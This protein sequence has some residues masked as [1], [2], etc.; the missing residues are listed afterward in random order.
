ME[1][2][3][4]GFIVAASLMLLVASTYIPAVLVDRLLAKNDELVL[5]M[6][7]IVNSFE[8]HRQKVEDSVFRER[9]L[10]QGAQP[11]F[12]P[13][14]IDRNELIT[15][16]ANQLD[17]AP[18]GPQ[19]ST[20]LY[21]CNEGY[22]MV[23]YISDRFGFRNSD[24]V[25][26][27]EDK[28]FVIGD[29]FVHG[30]CMP[31][32]SN[33]ITGQMHEVGNVI[34][35][36]SGSNAPIHYAAIAK[37]IVS[38]FEPKKVIM[39]FYPNDNISDQRYNEE[40]YFYKYYW[41]RRPSSYF[42]SEPPELTLNSNLKSFYESVGSVLYKSISGSYEISDD[43]LKEPSQYQ[44]SLQELFETIDSEW[45]F[46]SGI[47]SSN[48]RL[49]NIRTAI[50][51]LLQHRGADL[52]FAAQLAIDELARVCSGSCTP[53]V[54]YIPES[55]LRRPDA[56][57]DFF[58]EQL[59]TYSEARGIKFVNTA[60]N[61]RS[62]DESDIYALKGPHLSPLGNKLVADMISAELNN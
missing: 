33:T 60:P 49:N 14:L 40:S 41:N 53:A 45:Q 5:E 29:S 54:A 23:N 3:K 27:K 7:K 4:R 50:R 26:D 15:Q 61:L 8:L 58:A 21:Y 44:L 17:V 32:E 55:K 56:R 11:V 12:F 2:I 51:F 9:L 1:L 13:D 47:N 28:V 35:L 46:V 10:S 48:L 20:F 18:L 6:Q 34:N 62:R 31:K 42:E 22:G 25:W 24:E 43:F 39:V 16:L 30:A 38:Q 37:E 57:A 52:P 36:G 19:P 59:A